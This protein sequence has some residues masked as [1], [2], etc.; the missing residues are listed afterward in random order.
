[1]DRYP[2][3]DLAALVGAVAVVTLAPAGVALLRLF[4]PLVPGEHGLGWLL[5]VAGAIAVAAVGAATLACLERGME[6][7]N[8]AEVARATALGLVGVGLGV[9]SLR[10]LAPPSGIFFPDAGLAP[11]ALGAGALLLAAQLGGDS[12]GAR[13]LRLRPIATWLA[14]FGCIEVALAA[15]VLLPPAGDAWP[16]LVGLASALIAASLVPGPMLAAGLLAAG[17]AALAASRLGTVET[18]LGLAAVAA[19]A[20]GYARPSVRPAEPVLDTA[21]A[22]ATAGPA[23]FGAAEPAGDVPAALSAQEESRRL[24][25]ELRGTIEELMHARRTIELQ[26]QEIAQAASVDELTGVATRRAILDRLR[27]EAGEARRYQHSVAVVL[28][29]LDGFAA[30]NRDHGLRVGDE[31]LREVA[32][33]L[34]VRMRSADAIGRVGGDSFMALLPHTDETGAATFADALRRRLLARPIETGAGEI[35]VSVSI[36]VAFMRAGMGLTDEELLAA[37]DEALASARAAGGNRIAFDR[38]HGLVRLEERRAEPG[39]A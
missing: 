24:A 2:R 18:M 10:A 37:A 21:A 14:V 25:R 39:G 26:R 3:P 17:M 12:A 29:D 32:L 19:G 22:P 34:R 6:R 35:V 27:V 33:R 7:G 16:W 20:A 23:R 9:A 15:A 11:A 31:V 36:G 5:P 4:P 28:L 8:L 13:G 30:I 1:V 38:M